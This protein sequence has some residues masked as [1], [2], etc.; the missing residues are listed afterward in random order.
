MRL[1]QTEQKA[2]FS[3]KAFSPA[4]LASIA[5]KPAKWIVFLAGGP[6]HGFETD[7]CAQHCNYIEP[8]RQLF[9][10]RSRRRVAGTVLQVELPRNRYPPRY[11]LCRRTRDD[12]VR[13]RTVERPA[14]RAL[15]GVLKLIPKRHT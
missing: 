5:D 12:T 11:S 3:E 15:L 7:Y 4:A 14:R 9:G 13:I 10:E 8:E 6:R 1:K 2:L